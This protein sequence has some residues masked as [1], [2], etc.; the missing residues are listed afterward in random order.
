MSPRCQCHKSIPPADLRDVYRVACQ[1][2][3]Q[4]LCACHERAGKH[5]PGL[6]EQLSPACRMYQKREFD[7]CKLYGDTGPSECWHLGKE[8]KRR[9]DL[10]PTS[11]WAP[12]PTATYRN[13][14]CRT[15]GNRK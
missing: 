10:L 6:E 15:S 5:S 4:D 7:Q 11:S 1:V 3:H 2:S 9:R 14:R 12:E 13:W 8:T